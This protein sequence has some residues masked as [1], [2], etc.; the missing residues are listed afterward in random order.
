MGQRGPGTEIMTLT[1][2]INERLT[3]GP[4]RLEFDSKIQ[5]R[6]RGDD[7]LVKACLNGDEQAWND[8]VDKYGRLVFHITRS[9]NLDAA[10]ADDVFQIVFLNVLRRLS[11]LKNTD[12]L[13]SWLMTITYREAQRASIAKR[14]VVQLD[15]TVTD[16][17][18]PPFEKIHREFLAQ[19]VQSALQQLDTFSREFLQG[20]MA[21]PAP[22]YEEI[23]RRLGMPLGSVGPTRARCLK[24]L[25]AILKRMG[26]EL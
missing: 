6:P 22:S 20:L 19:Q 21:D 13:T 15:E 7:A 18:E 11:S 4:A 16:H 5:D 26:V 17:S 14:R 25:E 2:N 12:S 1:M 8:L 23:S 9:Y 10:E 3:A 24:K